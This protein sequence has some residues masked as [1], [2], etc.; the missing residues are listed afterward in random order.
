VSVKSATALAQSAGEGVTSGDPG[1]PEI[2]ARKLRIAIVCVLGQLFAGNLVFTGSVP[3]L[4]LPM[5]REFGWTR[6]EFAYSVTALMWCGGAATPLLGRFADRF[7]VRPVMLTGTFIMGVVTLGLSHQTANLWRMWFS[8]AVIGLCS[9]G[10]YVFNTKVI[11]ALFHRQRGKA[12]ALFGLSYPIGLAIAPQVS[13]ALLI[14]FGWRGIYTGNAM[15]M[16]AMLPVLYFGLEEPGAG[17]ATDRSKTPGESSSSQLQGLTASETRRSKTLW[18][19]IAAAVLSGAPVVGWMPHMVAFTIGRGFSQ[20]AAVNMLSISSMASALFVLLSGYLVDRISTAK[21][22]VPF[23]LASALGYCFLMICSAQFGGL[24]LLV[25][26]VTLANVALVGGSMNGYYYTRFFGFKGLA[27][28][29][30]THMACVYIAS[31]LAP[32]LIGAVFQRTGSYGVALG[33]AMMGQVLAIGAF[34]F[35][36]PYRYAA[37]RGAAHGGVNTAAGDSLLTVD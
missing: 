30:G 26:G 19:L 5:T 17:A 18:L 9:S 25:T 32:P 23:A 33:V 34:M 37:A 10:M 11:S 6:T 2:T 4:M 15:L 21:S 35:L 24:P 31:G 8:F 1:E 22:F 36:G 16:L 13:N 12:L 7:G 28:S 14:H 29:L 27:E 20:Q 3:L